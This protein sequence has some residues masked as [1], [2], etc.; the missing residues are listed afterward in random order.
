MAT[1]LSPEV[2]ELALD[3][4]R[5]ALPADAVLTGEDELRDLPRPV[6]VPDVGR[7]TPPRRC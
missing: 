1:V 7:L 6:R 2:S 4:F 5:A 3:A